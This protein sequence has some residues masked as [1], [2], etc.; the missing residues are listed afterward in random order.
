[1]K[2]LFFT[3][4]GTALLAVSCTKDYSCTCTETYTAGGQVTTY[5]NKY[6]ISEASSKQA[7]I[8]CNE[9]TII[10]SGTTWGGNSYTSEVTCELK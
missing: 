3:I 6:D 8:A 10:S 9:A 5:V 4:I 1:M 2:K 7:K